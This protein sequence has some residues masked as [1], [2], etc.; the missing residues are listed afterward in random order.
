MLECSDSDLTLILEFLVPKYASL[1]TRPILAAL[2]SLCKE[3]YSLN[4]S[5]FLSTIIRT[6]DRAVIRV[7][8]KAN[9]GSNYYTLLDSVNHTLLVSVH[10]HESFEKYLPDLIIWQATLLDRCLAESKKRSLRISALQTTRT[11]LRGIF[12]QKESIWNHNAVESYIRVLMSAK[13]T[14]FIAAVM[15]GVVADVCKRL[16]NDT[17]RAVL[18]SSKTAFYEF[19]RKELVGSKVRIPSYVIV[20]VDFGRYI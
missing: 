19:F 14:S 2:H 10:D 9:A 1:Q 5:I 16:R 11:C 4:N 15:L 13:V 17:P 7:N 3:L 18:E 8:L 20:C 12:Q 6:L